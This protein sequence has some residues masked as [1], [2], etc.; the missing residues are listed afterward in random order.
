MKS[1]LCWLPVG[2]QTVAV[3]HQSFGLPDGLLG[4]Y[5]EKWGLACIW[6]LDQSPREAVLSDP[7]HEVV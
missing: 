2:V 4:E 7:P 5:K 6:L 3:L 1:V